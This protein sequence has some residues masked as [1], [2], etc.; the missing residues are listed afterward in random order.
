MSQ[1]PYLRLQIPPGVWY[2]FC[3]LSQ[4]INL[5]IAIT[6]KIFNENDVKRLDIS[7]LKF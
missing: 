4:N 7:E 6:D 5:I 3:G 1:N 2:G